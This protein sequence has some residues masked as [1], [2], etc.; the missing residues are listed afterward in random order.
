MKKLNLNAIRIDGETQARV[1]LSESTVAEY[2]ECL[3]ALPPVVVFFDGSDN[4]L[5]DGFHRFHAYRKAGKASIPADIRAGTQREARLYSFGA[6]RAHGLRMTNADKRKAVGAML[7]DAEWGQWSDR[8]IADACGVSHTFVAIM[9]K[10]PEVAT[11]ATPDPE[12]CGNV[13]T[14]KAGKVATVATPAPA[15]PPKRTLDNRPA[16]VPELTADDELAEARDT[17]AQIAKENEELRDKLAVEQMDA[18]EEAKGE[19]A[20]TIRELRERVRVLEIELDAVKA[21]R[22]GYMRETAEL[23]KQCAAQRRELDKLRKVAA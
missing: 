11:V 7:A 8:K 16:D 10:P 14:P 13:S 12:Q 22:D 20:E 9:R 23:K 2:A 21:S 15:K 3:E 17:L 18:S 4:W 6:N 19:A 5:A 1:S